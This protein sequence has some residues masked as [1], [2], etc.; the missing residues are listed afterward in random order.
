M[1]VAMYRSRF[2]DLLKNL[3]AFVFMAVS[4]L[5]FP[6]LDLANSASLRT[7]RILSTDGQALVSGGAS[8]V[9]LQPHC[10]R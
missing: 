9:S 6:A 3:S 7:L 8:G 5:V 2:F 10:R 1:G 4:G